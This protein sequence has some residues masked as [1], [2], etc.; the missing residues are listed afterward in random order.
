MGFYLPKKAR[1]KKKVSFFDQNNCDSSDDDDEK[2]NEIPRFT[3]VDS[4]FL[5]YFAGNTCIITIYSQH[6]YSTEWMLG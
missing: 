3:E 2:K 5:F 4:F 6:I 1:R